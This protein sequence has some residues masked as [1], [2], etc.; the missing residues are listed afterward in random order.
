MRLP[1]GLA[2]QALAGA[3]PASAVPQVPDLAEAR[4]ARTQA[5]LAPA[6][7]TRPMA[8]AQGGAT[9]VALGIVASAS[10]A[11]A[12]LARARAALP[13]NETAVQLVAEPFGSGFRIVARGFP[14][15]QS[16]Q[17]FCAQAARQGLV[18]GGN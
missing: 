17:G 12:A 13:E 4:L 7:S 18:C 6:A 15:V 8:A 10:E 5:P 14:S 3:I 16:A 2:A 9:A 1:P 11:R